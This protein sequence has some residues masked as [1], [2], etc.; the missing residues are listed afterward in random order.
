MKYLLY[1]LSVWL[2]LAL[3]IIPSS[4]ATI[5]FWT[6]ETQSDRLKTIQL[7]MDTFQAI[8]PDIIV[9]LI[10]VD[11]ND[12]ASQMAAASAAGNMPG[13]IEASSELIMAF[14]KEG[15]ID[16]EN[17]TEIVNSIGK[18]RFYRGAL[19]MVEMPDA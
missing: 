13:L 9:R 11:E 10:P 17:T 12:I 18:D 19:N 14:G 15:I 8:N 2:L 5:E 3:A 7:L 1:S 4:A 16:V 6:S